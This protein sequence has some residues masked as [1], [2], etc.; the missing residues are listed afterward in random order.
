[1]SQASLLQKIGNRSAR[2]GIIGL[3]YVGLPVALTFHD[4][5]FHVLGFDIDPKKTEA[6]A[7][8]Q[9]YIKTIDHTRIAEAV[10]DGD[11]EP[12]SDFSR[13]G[14]PD[15][16]LLCL[17]T[18]LDTHRQPDL[19]YVTDT[20]RQLVPHLHTG[21]LV[22]LESTTFPGT[23]CDILRP[24]LEQS[25]LHVGIDIFL[26]FSPEREDPGNPGFSTATI[27]KV[28]GGCTE[29]CGEVAEALYAAAIDTVH[30]V[31][32]AATA[33]LS[34]L[35]ENIFR[36]VNI[37]LVNELKVLADRMG[38]D[39][40]EVIDA[41][42]TKPFGFM[43]F[44]PGPG[45][46]GHCLPIDPFYLTWKAREF[47]LSTRFIEL[48]GEINTAMPRYV[49]ERLVLA[50]NQHN[51]SLKDSSIIIIG[52][53]YKPDVD[54]MRES[55]SL[56]LISLLTNAGATVSYHDP[57]IPRLPP[58]RRYNFDMHSVDLTEETLQACDAV[59]IATHHSAC[60]WEFICTHAPLVVDTRNATASV[61][62][63]RDH[64]VKA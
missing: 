63:E 13:L 39:I 8:G 40:W 31:S 33:E 55:P 5:G 17:P 6:L 4:A 30:R 59:I 26:A 50:L 7:Q 19:S 12:T 35:L 27:P 64:I 10:L 32:N 47:G 53:A 22:V 54:D 52:A 36:S 25:G 37:A 38:L 41:A 49:I 29:A 51:K 14:E 46:G 3:G 61:A 28:V 24:I 44:Y 58:T 43:P 21:Q 42:S 56:E 16:V 15:A 45:L 1:M 34:K 23:T 9:S 20:A 2:V 11:F 48:A 60:D 62:G 18:P 57:H